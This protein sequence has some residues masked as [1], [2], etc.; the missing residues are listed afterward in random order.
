M[1]I[2]S[3]LS[4]LDSRYFYVDVFFFEE[5]KVECLGTMKL[6]E[7]EFD[8][9]N[10]SFDCKLLLMSDDELDGYVAEKLEEKE[11]DNTKEEKY[12]DFKN[13]LGF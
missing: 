7:D 5:D 3:K 12:Y 2:A 11:L 1:K 8:E 6:D 9:V 13:A 4:I 10:V